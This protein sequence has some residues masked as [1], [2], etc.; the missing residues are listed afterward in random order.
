MNAFKASLAVSS[1]VIRKIER[2]TMQQRNSSLWFE[3]RRTDLLH[4]SLGKLPIGNQLHVH[5]QHLGFVAH[6]MDQL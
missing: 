3:V 2:E 4:L 5:A 6:W 1:E